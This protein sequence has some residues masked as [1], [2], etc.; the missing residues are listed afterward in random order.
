MRQPCALGP[1]KE[2]ICRGDTQGPPLTK[3][4]PKNYH[5]GLKV[6]SRDAWAPSHI[7]KMV[8]KFK[9]NKEKIIFIFI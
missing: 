3:P 9:E 6:E 7:Y 8:S 5:S 4:T 2:I 1:N